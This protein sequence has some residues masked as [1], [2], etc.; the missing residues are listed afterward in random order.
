MVNMD[1]ASDLDVEQYWLQ[2]KPEESIEEELGKWIYE[3]RILS[4]ILLGILALLLSIL[5]APE[6]VLVITTALLYLAIVF[7]NIELRG[8]QEGQNEILKMGKRPLVEISN[9]DFDTSPPQYVISN[10]GPGYATHL[11]V[12]SKIQIPMETEIEPLAASNRITRNDSAGVER[13]D[14]TVPPN[15]EAIIFEGNPK[16]GV[17]SGRGKQTMTVQGATE[18]LIDEDIN[19]INYRIV[20]VYANPLGEVGYRALTDI[21]S[22]E[23]QEP[24][25]FKG[26][27]NQSFPLAGYERDTFPDF[28]LGDI[29]HTRDI[30]ELREPAVF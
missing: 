13:F 23:F 21:R 18:Y 6:V 22:V 4:F 20:L 5:I 29:I 2:Q 25:N 15:K 11:A 26:L 1:N 10:F 30:E 16:I 7:V 24:L 3:N 9:V 17:K 14:S 8:L 12:V 28:D 27:Q 19:R